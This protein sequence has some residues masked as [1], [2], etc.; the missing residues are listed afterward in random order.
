MATPIPESI[1]KLKYIESI[2]SASPPDQVK[3]YSDLMVL[4]VLETDC[5]QI[6]KRREEIDARVAAAA[7]QLFFKQVSNR[8][9]FTA[10]YLVQQCSLSAPFSAKSFLFE[11]RESTFGSLFI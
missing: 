7:T 2:K 1:L 11:G 6:A 4:K 10:P 5:R 3:H 9:Q 8:R